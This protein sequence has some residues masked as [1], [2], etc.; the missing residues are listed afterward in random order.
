MYIGL[1][2]IGRRCLLITFVHHLFNPGRRKTLLLI[3]I[4]HDR[5]HEDSRKVLRKSKRYAG[6]RDLQ[7]GLIQPPGVDFNQK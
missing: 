1:P 4:K 6:G 7:D 5:C 2:F 3:I